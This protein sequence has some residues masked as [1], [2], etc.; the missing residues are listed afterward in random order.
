[1][2]HPAGTS[3]A[4]LVVITLATVAVLLTVCGSA[5]AGDFRVR[6]DLSY[7]LDRRPPGVESLNMLDLYAPEHARRGT[8][9]PV[10][11][12][13][14]GGGWRRGDKANVVTDK[15]RLFT[16]AGYLFASVNYRL[17]PDRITPPRLAPRR[18]MFPDQP[19]DVGEAVCWVMRHSRA[20]GAD[21]HRIVLVGHSAGAQLVSLVATAGRYLRAYG[22]SPRGVRGVV[23]LDGAAYDVRAAA[24]PPPSGPTLYTRMIWNAF[25]S[26]AENARRHTWRKASAVVHADRHDPRF[27]L[28]TQR[29]RSRIHANTELARSLRQMRFRPVLPVP[30]SHGEINRVL[31]SPDDP[32][33]ETGRTMA[34]VHNRLADR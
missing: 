10:V 22:C 15:A 3:R 11:I 34:F 24:T 29:K 21:R 9:R 19:H 25:G 23:A 17:S 33:R 2:I 13:V 20:L 4:R 31:G 26:P 14:H 27:L 6:H 12:Y 1:M 8:P 18:V 5:A 7:N 30:L 16:G 28:V 32:T